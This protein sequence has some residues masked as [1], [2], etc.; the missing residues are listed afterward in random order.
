MHVIFACP[1]CEQPCRIELTGAADQEL[2]C[3]G[4]GRH[5]PVPEGAV[6]GDKIRRCVV[7][8]SDELFVRKDFSQRLGVAI[9][10][11]GF[12]LSSITW[13]YHQIVATYAILFATA[14]IDVVLYV[15][16]GNVLQC[17]RCQAQYRGLADLE[18]H[19]AFSLETHERHRQQEARMAE[20]R[21]RR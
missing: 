18:G 16:V 11:T 13:Y 12:V 9:V 5:W 20:S 6:V 19:G 4:C 21:P 1:D 17:Y 8:P 14:L 2:R 15:L 3:T 10:V 7:C